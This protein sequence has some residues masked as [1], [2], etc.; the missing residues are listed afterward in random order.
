M[1]KGGDDSTSHPST[2]YGLSRREVLGS[3]AAGISTFAATG[4]R[5]AA[6]APAGD[7]GIGILLERANADRNRRIL[8]RG[9]TIISMDPAVGNFARGDILIEGDKIAGVGPNLSAGGGVIEVE[10]G[11]MIIIPGFCDPH[12][13]SW[14]GQLARLIPNQNDDRSDTRRSYFTVMHDT[15]AHAYRPEDMYIGTLITMLAAMNGGITTVCDNSHNSRSSA[16]SDAAIQALFDS[17]IRGV[18][19][20]GPPSSGRWDEQWPQDMYRI[21]ERYFS[22]EDQLV[23]LRLFPRGS[24]PPDHPAVLKARRDLNLWFSFDGAANLPIE[25]LYA[26]GILNGKESFNH[27]RGYSKAQ[28]QAIV[29]H[30]AKV[31][32]CPRVDS[33]FYTF[34]KPGSPA[35]QEWLDSGA[36]PGIS[37]DDPATFGIDM[38]AE[39]HVLYAFQRGMANFNDLPLSKRLTVRDVLELATLRG[40]ECCAL[41]HKVGTLTPGKQADIVMINTNDVSLYPKHNAILSVVEGATIGHVDTV[42]IAGTL[43]KWRGALKG[44]DL[45]RIRHMVEESRDFLFAKTGWPLPTIDFAD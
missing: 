33:Q 26:A 25:N 10:V 5:E 35:T 28:R 36:L 37:G 23:T 2:A 29:E 6:A 12:I 18:H 17:G 21:K 32:I 3:T 15:F 16:H 30:G 13:H 14:Q 44:F 40:A 7:E 19:A 42:F 24:F 11:E 20:S 4:L 43:R 38:F 39:M 27:G 8:L 45:N 1:S 41:D 34:T 22:S 31:N 9:G